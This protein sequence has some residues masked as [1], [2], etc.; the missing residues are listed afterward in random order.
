[1][2]YNEYIMCTKNAIKKKTIHELPLKCLEN[3]DINVILHS[4]HI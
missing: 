2:K 1:M 4:D 3:V